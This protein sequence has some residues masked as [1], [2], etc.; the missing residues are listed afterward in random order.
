MKDTPN[1]PSHCF[2]LVRHVGLGLSGLFWLGFM[3][4]ILADHVMV[5]KRLSDCG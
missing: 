1:S 4:L 2:T 3:K 5:G